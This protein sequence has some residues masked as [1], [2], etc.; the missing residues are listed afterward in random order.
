MI[1]LNHA[2]AVPKEESNS[3][4]APTRERLLRV[5]LLYMYSLAS[6]ALYSESV[7]RLRYLLLVLN[8]CTSCC[9]ACDGHTEGGAADVVETDTMTELYG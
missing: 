8:G 2:S 5:A 6:E 4:E 3:P 7:A 1:T 9:Q